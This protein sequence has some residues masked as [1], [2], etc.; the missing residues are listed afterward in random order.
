[1]ISKENLDSDIDE[2]EILKGV[3]LHLQPGE[4]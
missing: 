4:I 2:N 1:M 3:G